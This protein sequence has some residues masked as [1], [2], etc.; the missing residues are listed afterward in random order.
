MRAALGFPG[1]LRSDSQSLFCAQARLACPC[2]L[3]GLAGAQNRKRTPVPSMAA[4]DANS[5]P[6]VR[7]NKTM[8][9][10]KYSPEHVKIMLPT[11]QVA[12]TKK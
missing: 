11:R 12:A 3:P 9:D 8:C 1:N 2:E 7:S 5:V 10:G 6:L 4:P